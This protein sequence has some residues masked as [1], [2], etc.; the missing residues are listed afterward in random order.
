MI[1][2]SPK[3]GSSPL[4]RGLPPNK[5]SRPH[6]ERIIPARAGFTPRSRGCGRHGPDHPRSRGV[7]IQS[8]FTEDD[9][10]GSSPLARGLPPGSSRPVRHA[11]DHPRSRGVYPII[12]QIIHLGQGS[13][14]LA[15]GLL[16]N[17]LR[18]HC[19]R[20]I[21]PARAGFTWSCVS[22]RWASWDHPRS[23]GVYDMM[24]ITELQ[25]LGSSPL[26]RGLRQLHIAVRPRTRIIPARAGFTF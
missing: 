14:P 18:G 8:Y 11:S 20:R 13:S 26:A 24:V 1:F 5:T 23:R 9:G 25:E 4:A 10:T 16:Q 21:I 22:A 12:Q 6:T 3:S 7:Y 2:S 19:S 17:I 15:R